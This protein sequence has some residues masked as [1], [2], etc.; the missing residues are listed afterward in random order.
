M[1]A[2]QSSTHLLVGV[3]GISPCEARS[4]LG[5]AGTRLEEEGLS[6]TSSPCPFRSCSCPCP[7]PFPCRPTHSRPS[8]RP[9]A[10]PAGRCSEALPGPSRRLEG[11]PPCL[12][13]VSA[14]ASELAHPGP[15][16]AG[17]VTGCGPESPSPAGLA[18]SP[19][20]RRSGGDGPSLAGG[21]RR[22]ASAVLAHR[23][24]SGAVTRAVQ[25][26]SVVLE[27]P[28]P[29]EDTESGARPRPP[30]PALTVRD[31]FSGARCFL[32]ASPRD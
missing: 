10:V 17:A 28:A 32:A 31:A 30:A 4:R 23:P 5:E 13:W 24:P 25:E 11:L 3:K 27:R 7:S 22:P 9:W 20:P 18:L 1:A 8:A 2:A 12:R 15:A 19:D 6:S 21:T 29:D 14:S 26:S 16:P